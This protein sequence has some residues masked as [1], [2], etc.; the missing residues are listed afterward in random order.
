MHDTIT[1]H[2]NIALRNED[3]KHVP[4]TVR[5]LNYRFVAYAVREIYGYLK[6]HVQ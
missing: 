2:S 3:C 6:I 5:T 4:K 1:I